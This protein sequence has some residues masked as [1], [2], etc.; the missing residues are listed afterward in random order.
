MTMRLSIISLAGMALNAG[1]GG[2]CS[3]RFM[4]LTIA[5]AGPRGILFSSAAGA[6]GGL[7]RRPLADAD[8]PRPGGGLDVGL[9]GGCRFARRLLPVRERC[10]GDLIARLARSC[11]LSRCGGRGGGGGGPGCGGRGGSLRLGRAGAALPLLE[12][13]LPRRRPPIRACSSSGPHANLGSTE[14]GSL[15]VLVHLLDQPGVLSEIRETNCSLRFL[16]SIPS[17]IGRLITS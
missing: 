2:I 5:A 3:D 15:M 8:E 4:F 17:G 9:S 7:W 1:R 6:A 14:A 11:G 12:V 16:A 10:R 13:G